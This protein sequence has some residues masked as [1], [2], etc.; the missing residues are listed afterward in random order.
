MDA[1]SPRMVAERFVRAVAESDMTSVAELMDPEV[2]AYIT[3][4]SGGAD[5]V[6]GRDDLA[7]RFPDFASMADSFSI[8]ITQIHE[9]DGHAVMFMVEINAER[10]GM[11]LHN[12]AGILLTVS[13][14]GTVTE[15]RMVEARPEYSD[16]F[17]SATSV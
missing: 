17:W 3:N 14:H 11:T 8:G 2:R 15:Y 1:R 10:L 7:R 4:A 9:I 12:F 13:G 16:R 5:L 6:T